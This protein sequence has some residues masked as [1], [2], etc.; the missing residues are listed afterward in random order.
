MNVTHDCKV[1]MW[2]KLAASHGVDYADAALDMFEKRFPT[3]ANES[4]VD[5]DI[6]PWAHYKRTGLSEMRPYVQ[7]EDLASISVSDEDA[8]EE[9]GMIARNPDN[10]ANQWYVAKEYFQKNLEPAN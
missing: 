3:Q 2:T 5:N 10:H 7:G 6:S 4:R 8:P 9:G 1:N